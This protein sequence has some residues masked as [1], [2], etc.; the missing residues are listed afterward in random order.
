MGIGLWVRHLWEM[1][2]GSGKRV[3]CDQ[4][5]CAIPLSDFEKG[6]AVVIAR[7]KYCHS[8]IEEVTRKAK[9]RSSWALDM[10]SSSTVY[11]K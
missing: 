4:C 1:V 5:R 10:G 11:L 2:G 7:Q 3:P 6:S 8:C 9:G